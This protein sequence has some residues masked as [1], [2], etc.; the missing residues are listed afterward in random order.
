MRLEPGFRAVDV[1]R[2]H[3]R[4]RPELGGMIHMTQ[5]RAFVRREIVEHMRPAP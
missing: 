4:Q 2:Q 1:G 5:M 3:V